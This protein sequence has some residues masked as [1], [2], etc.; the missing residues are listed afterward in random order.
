MITNDTPLGTLYH[1]AKTCSLAARI[2]A[3]EGE[4]PIDI[5]LLDLNTK[6]L[7][8][9]G[10]LY[11]VNPLGQ[12]STFVFPDGEI[13]TETGAVLL[14]LQSQSPD[15]EF[16]RDPASRA[17]YQVARWVGFVATEIHKQI[18]RTVFYSEATEEV[19]DRIR[20]LA[21]E[22]FKTLDAHLATSPFLVSDTFSAADAYLAWAFT[23]MDRAGIDPT[24]Y[25]HLNAYRERMLARPVVEALVTEDWG[26]AG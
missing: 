20:A 15:P 1:A 16:H 5:V 7:E 24:G 8:G 14:W 6:A 10:S 9:G 25:E 17:F 12:V 2:A 26:K 11:D 4:T 13:L 18:F 19:K 3:A 21:P 22:R 23:L